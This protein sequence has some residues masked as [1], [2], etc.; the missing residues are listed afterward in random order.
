MNIIYKSQNLGLNIRR[1]LAVYRRISGKAQPLPY[2]V[3]W[4]STRRCNLRCTH[5]GASTEKYGKELD[6][7]EIKKV[8]DELSI[9]KNCTFGATGGEPFLRED[10]LEVMKFAKSKGMRTGIASNGM[11]IDHNKALEIKR[12]DVNYIQISIDG[13]EEI[14][15]NIRKNNES[16]SKAIGAIKELIA[17]GIPEVRV[18][19]T[20]T[21]E[22]IK[23]LYSIKKILIDLN[24]ETWRLVTIMPIGRADNPKN[25]LLSGNEMR[26]VFKIVSKN[27]SPLNIYIGESLPYLGDYEEKIRH[28]PLKCPVGIFAFCI[29]VNGN[30]RGCPE[31]PDTSEFIEGNIRESSVIDIWNR[32]FT[33]YRKRQNDFIDSKCANCSK[34]KFCFG[35]CW[36]MRIKNMNCIYKILK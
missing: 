11:L 8:I 35:G 16:F 36:V 20:V 33:K 5:C 12:A 30:V 14:H 31:Q 26:K 1:R 24:V 17:V 3:A 21:K 28:T 29:G 22:N 15:N 32:G 2:F 19:T 4:D 23:H 6:T 9:V 34:F 7:N 13:P 18:A 10:L 27:R 25:F